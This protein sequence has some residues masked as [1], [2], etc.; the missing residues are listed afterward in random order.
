[1]NLRRLQYFVDFARNPGPYADGLDWASVR[2]HIA[3]LEKELGFELVHRQ[4]PQA[5][6]L[7]AAGR[8]YAGHAQRI[9][10]TQ[11]QM[12]ALSADRDQGQAGRLRIGLCEEACTLY[13]ARALTRFS[14]RFPGVALDVVESD[15]TDLARAVRRRDVD[16]ALTLPLSSEEGLAV[17]EAWLDRWTVALPPGHPLQARTLIRCEDLAAEPLVL[18]DPLLPSHGHEYIRDAFRRRR[19]EVQVGAL[20]INR[21]TMLVLTVGGMGLTFVPQAMVR[22]PAQGDG[23]VPLGFRLLDVPPLRICAVVALHSPPRTALHFVQ[24][25]DATRGA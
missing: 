15:S 1:M 21:T 3:V 16:I 12:L 2:K 17:R 9:L 7:T 14:E 8:H 4:G 25:V 24:I 11:R 23:L 18:A 13:F 5:R 10:Q 6:R 22:V 20:G 19:I